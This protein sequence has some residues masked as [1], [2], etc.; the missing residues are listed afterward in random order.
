MRTHLAKSLNT[1]CKA[2]ENAAKAYNI[3]AR[4]VDPPRPALDWVTVS[5]YSFLED[6]E[7]LRD[8]RQDIHQKPWAQPVARLALKQA[9]RIQRAQE[10]IDNCNIDVRRLHTH[11]LD[12]NEDFSGI[13]SDLRARAD[14]ILGAVEDYCTR[15]RRVNVQLLR[16]VC[17]IHAISGFSGITSRGRRVGR[18][19]LTSTPLN[20]NVPPDQTADSDS[21]GDWEDED[22]IRT[23]YGGLVDYIAD[24]PLRT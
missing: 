19:N 7:L 21:D 6:F 16:R 13:L 17:D 20:I 14:P 4:A 23:E 10:E 18:A 24:M 8:T 5:H 22:D 15:R 11:I 12:E 9:Q 2:I 1:R 3:A